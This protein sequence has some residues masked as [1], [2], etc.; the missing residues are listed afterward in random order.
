MRIIRSTRSDAALPRGVSR[1]KA[2]SLLQLMLTVWVVLA[3]SA[4]AQPAGVTMTIPPGGV[5]LDGVVRP[6]SWT[7]LQLSLDNVTAGDRDVVLTWVYGDSD[8]DRV[9]ARRR[10]TLTRERP[11]QRAW[12]YAAAA[13]TTGETTR[14]TVTADDADTGRR[15]AT[16]AVEPDPSRLVTPGTD[17]VAVTSNADLGLNDYARHEDPPRAA[18]P[19]PGPVTGPLARPV[20]G[21]VGAGHLHLDPRSGGRPG[22]PAADLRGVAAGAA[23]VGLPRRAPGHRPPGGGADVDR[24]AP[25]GPA[26]GQRGRDADHQHDGL[27][28]VAG[29]AAPG[30]P[31]GAE[32]YRVR[33]RRVQHPYDGAAA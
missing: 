14:W 24:L 12:L 11:G 32:P 4:A 15:L 13:M 1:G 19:R 23:R 5:G 16:L 9:A 6:G 25:R 18:P 22:R 31:P 21:P 17:L 29:R 2:A 7:P 3:S 20:D 30:R 27:A 8:G 28:P 33:S 10:L 26:A